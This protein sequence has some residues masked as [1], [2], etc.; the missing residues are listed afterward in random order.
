MMPRPADLE[1]TRLRDEVRRLQ[2]ALD[3]L[4]SLGTLSWDDELARSDLLRRM[5]TAITAIS[6]LTERSRSAS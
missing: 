3:S 6:S 4:K 1:L 2:G 5:S